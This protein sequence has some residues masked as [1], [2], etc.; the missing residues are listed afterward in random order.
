MSNTRVNLFRGLSNALFYFMDENS[1]Q[2]RRSDEEIEEI[3]NM[4]TNPVIQ[5]LMN[6]AAF[7]WTGNETEVVYDEL[8]KD[9]VERL[10]NTKAP[11][12]WNSRYDERSLRQFAAVRALHNNSK[13]HKFLAYPMQQLMDLSKSSGTNLDFFK[14]YRGYVVFI[15]N[16]FPNAEAHM[17]FNI[18]NNVCVYSFSKRSTPQQREELIR[19][20]TLLA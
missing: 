3:I 11:F 6:M 2:V 8:C 9:F 10:R 19:L 5:A 4:Q 14:I 1:G 16:A 12:T 18:I 7:D 13:A 15:Y 17:L 20:L